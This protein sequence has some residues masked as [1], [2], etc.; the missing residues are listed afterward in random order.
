MLPAMSTPP[1]STPPPESDR[2]PDEEEI[3]EGP[4]PTPFDHPLF[5]PV[6]LCGLMLWFGYD[7]WLNT[8]PEMMEHR[9]FNRVGFAFLSAGTIYFGLKGYREWREDQEER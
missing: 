1:E 9:T 4:A 7:G 8:D 6:L 5:L 2:G 3:P